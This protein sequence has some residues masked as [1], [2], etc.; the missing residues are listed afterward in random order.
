M[1]V[2]RRVTMPE[3]LD[4]TSTLV[5]GWT[6][7]VATT[8]RAMSARSAFASWEG[9]NFVVLPRAAGAMPRTMAATRTVRP[10]HSQI[11][12][13]FLRCV[14]K[15]RSR[16]FWLS[17][18]LECGYAENGLVVPWTTEKFYTRGVSAVI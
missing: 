15:G 14:A 10:V 16:E 8:E 13:R 12:R 6:L 3:A 17:N 4:L 18:R 5:M 9:S 2:S 11:F 7:P 1:S